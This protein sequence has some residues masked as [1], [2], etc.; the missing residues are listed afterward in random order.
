MPGIC[1]AGRR[2]FAHPQERLPTETGSGRSLGLT[3]LFDFRYFGQTVF[4][5]GRQVCL[6]HGRQYTGEPRIACAGPA[7]F[8]EF[9]EALLEKRNTEGRIATSGDREIRHHAHQRRCIHLAHALLPRILMVHVY[10]RRPEQF[11]GEQ[12]PAQRKE[13]VVL[14]FVPAAIF[15]NRTHQQRRNPV[16]S[17][18]PPLQECLVP[19]PAARGN[20]RC[21]V[22]YLPVRPTFVE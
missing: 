10:P 17:L 5:T 11:G 12:K 15:R 9:G 18:Q 19:Q 13:M 6:I 16:R 4:L 7:D 22:P 20:Q 2:L 3:V 1:V 21:A 8:P 14:T